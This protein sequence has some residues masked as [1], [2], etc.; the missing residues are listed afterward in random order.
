MDAKAQRLLSAGRGGDV[1]GD[2]VDAVVRVCVVV[3]QGQVEIVG[4][5]GAAQTQF[6]GSGRQEV[7]AGLKLPSIL[8]GNPARRDA[9]RFSYWAA[10]PK[11][12]FEFRSGQDDPFGKLQQ[13]L[14]KY[15][16]E[17]Q[18]G[19]DSRFRGNDKED[20][21]NDARCAGNDKSR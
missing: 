3:D 14:D 11:D 10:Q 1:E 2:G 13:A 8:G 7:F 18:A 12:V 20:G 15:R 16:L 5:R 6:V 19:M 9:G 4:D 17:T 21:G